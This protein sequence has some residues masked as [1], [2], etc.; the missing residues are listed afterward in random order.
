MRGRDGDAG[1]WLILY[2]V[3]AGGRQYARLL[4]GRD[5]RAAVSAHRRATAIDLHR[6]GFAI[7]VM[8]AM[9]RGLV[10]SEGA[11]DSARRLGTVGAIDRMSACH[12]RH[13]QRQHKPG[14]QRRSRQGS[15]FCQ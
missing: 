3:V 1:G 9:N 4:Y 11:P 15:K 6:A 12:G 2:A 10:V 5:N 7:R 13:K 14:D 8:V